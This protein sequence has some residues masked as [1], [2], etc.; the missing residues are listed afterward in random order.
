MQ[1][2]ITPGG[3]VRAIY[4]EEITLDALVLQQQPNVCPCRSFV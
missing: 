4:A 1:L 3:R 2:V